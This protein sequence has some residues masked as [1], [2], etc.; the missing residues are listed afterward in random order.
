MIVEGI[1]VP[2]DLLAMNWV[3]GRIKIKNQLFGYRFEA[4]NKLLH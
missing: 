3:I 4:T 1:E 2:T